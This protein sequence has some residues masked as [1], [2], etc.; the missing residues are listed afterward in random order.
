MNDKKWKSFFLVVDDFLSNI[1]LAGNHNKIHVNLYRF[2]RLHGNKLS[3]SSVLAGIDAHTLRLWSMLVTDQSISF[4]FDQIIIG[5][6]VNA[7][8]APWPCLDERW[9]LRRT[10]FI[11]NTLL[12]KEVESKLIWHPLTIETTSSNTNTRCR[13]WNITK[14]SLIS[15]IVARSWSE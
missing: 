4:D 12:S 7:G 6:V 10:I 8:E 9:A 14:I 13:Y 15:Q 11:R 5:T 2:Y 1:S 3:V